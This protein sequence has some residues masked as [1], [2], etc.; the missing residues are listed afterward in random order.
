MRLGLTEFFCRGICARLSDSVIAYGALLEKGWFWQIKTWMFVFWSTSTFGT[1]GFWDWASNIHLLFSEDRFLAW[2]IWCLRG[3]AE[4][5]PWTTFLYTLSPIYMSLSWKGK[6]KLQERVLVEVVLC[7]ASE[8]LFFIWIWNTFSV[9][10]DLVLFSDFL[11]KPSLFSLLKFVIALKMFSA[12][13]RYLSM[14]DWDQN[15]SIA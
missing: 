1:P 4:V 12:E 15:W 7:A 9:L 10:N 8:L 3:H 13:F 2:R 5:Q 6:M 14:K 11:I